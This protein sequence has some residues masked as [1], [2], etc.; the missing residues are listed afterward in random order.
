MGAAHLCSSATLMELETRQVTS[1]A[2]A[3]ASFA[4][5]SSFFH[6]LASLIYIATLEQRN[7]R[8]VATR[9]CPPPPPCY[10]LFQPPPP[11]PRSQGPPPPPQE[12]GSAT[13]PTGG[14]DQK[15]SQSYIGLIAMAILNSRHRKLVLSDIYRWILD[16]YAYFRS[17]GPGWRNSIR[18]NLSLN[19]CFVKS[20]RSSNGK[21]HYWTVHPANLDD[22]LR[23]DF[24]RRR[25]QRK[26]RRAMGLAEGDQPPSSA[27]AVAAEERSGADEET[28]EW[29]WMFGCDEQQRPNNARSELVEEGARGQSEV[30]SG[31]RK[32]SFDVESLL[33]PDDSETLSGQWSR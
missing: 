10:A 20:G 27:A 17:R 18:H 2:A 32:R 19:D 6:P 5:S 25:A 29:K 9:H 1:A 11:P 14:E 16:H 3:A 12:M 15:P 31:V 21:G 28:D 7:A 23:G 4:S 24:R 22:F 8:F 26:A 30:K 33:A 13:G